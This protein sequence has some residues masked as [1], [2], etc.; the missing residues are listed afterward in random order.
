M[1]IKIQLF[2]I[3]VAS[4]VERVEDIF[5]IFSVSL[6]LLCDKCVSYKHNSYILSCYN[7]SIHFVVL[8][9]VEDELL[10]EEYIDYF[11]EV[12]KKISVIEY[13]QLRR[14]W[15]DY[16]KCTTDVVGFCKKTKILLRGADRL[17]LYRVH[18]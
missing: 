12:E 10:D 6:K 9:E 13:R 2:K 4:K 16:Q 8:I 15:L 17:A 1:C 5:N 11:A 14:N 7:F 18:V 3:S